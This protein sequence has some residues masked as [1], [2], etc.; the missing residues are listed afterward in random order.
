MSNGLSIKSQDE[1]LK[2]W[3][4]FSP[5]NG[6]QVASVSATV[7]YKTDLPSMDDVKKVSQIIISNADNY[8]GGV[9]SFSSYEFDEQDY[10]TEFR[11]SFQDF[12][13]DG[14]NFIIR[15]HSNGNKNFK[16]YQITLSD[17][18]VLP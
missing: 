4:K 5:K 15:G 13:Y 2:L 8:K 10:F 7:K 17:I 6:A 9:I 3:K 11:A 16:E 14:M 12:E 18:E 1:F